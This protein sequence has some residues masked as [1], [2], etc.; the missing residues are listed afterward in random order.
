M[1]IIQKILMYCYPPSYADDMNREL[2]ATRP[3]VVEDAP[4]IVWMHRALAEHCSYPSFLFNITEDRVRATITNESSHESYYV[5]DDYFVPGY[6]EIGGYV[7]TGRSPMSWNGNRGI[8]IED[9]YV[10]PELRNGF[11][12]GTSLLA[13]VA[14]AAIDLADGNADR[15]FLRLDTSNGNN[16]PTMRFYEGKGFEGNNTNLR[17]QGDAIKELANRALG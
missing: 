17:L 6:R 2:V 8:Y 9:L 14:C 10:K 16:D 12:I 11:G 4:T 1:I 15:A 13:R 3:A 5:A 7:Y